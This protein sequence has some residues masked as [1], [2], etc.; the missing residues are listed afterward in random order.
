MKKIIPIIIILILLAIWGFNSNSSS[1][2]DEKDP[3]E[4]TTVQRGDMVISLK[5]SGFLNATKEIEIKN[6]I[7]LQSLNIIDIIEDGTFV[8]EGEFLVELD[9]SPLIE[10][11]ESIEEKVAERTLKVNEA[12]NSLEITESEVESSIIEAKNQIDFAE[13]DLAKFVNLERANKLNDAASEIS[14]AQDQAK[15]AEQT[16]QASVELA[17]KG[18]ETKST[19]DRHKLDLETNQ[20]Q[21]KTAFSKQEILIEYDLPKEALTLKLQVEETKNRL[22]RQKKEGQNKIQRSVA[23]L[24]NA[25]L[26]LEKAKINEAN[27]IAELEHIK[28]TSP[29]TGYAL[30][31]KSKRQYSNSNNELAKGVSVTRNQTL[32]RIPKM[33]NMKIDISVAEYFIS[34]IAVGQ[35][36][37]I[38]IDS[39][40]DQKFSGTVSNISL[41]PIQQSYWEKGGTQ[42]YNVTINVDDTT[43][44]EDIKPQ[45]SATAEVL[46]DELVDTVFVPIQSVH[47]VEG[48]RV[49]YIKSSNELG[50]E[51]RE[52]KIGQLNT[53]F[54]QILSG[55][56]EGLEILVSN[57][58]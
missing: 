43:L 45:I 2:G 56:E 27:I 41:L 54:I 42:K 26:L 14:V 52:V 51:Q 8:K 32:M 48:K 19:V 10:E 23:A 40:K 57:P 12:K 21:L 11:K 13:I 44:P 16:Y 28:I 36:A 58:N 17:D 7:S 18:F 22:L 3:I 5:E 15:F 46:L 49:V 50:Y 39:I 47:T 4:F 1:L 9:S 55:I 25:E 35:K 6:M 34:D 38:N 20:R 31:P 37:I 53:S 33:D 30:F 29:V 24:K